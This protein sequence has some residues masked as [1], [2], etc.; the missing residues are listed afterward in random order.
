M[1]NEYVNK[2]F[3]RTCTFDLHNASI[4]KKKKKKKKK[5]FEF[6]RTDSFHVSLKTGVF[7][8]L[9]GGLENFY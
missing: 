8:K 5:I 9:T 4:K 1:K 3:V 2:F 7:G 6:N